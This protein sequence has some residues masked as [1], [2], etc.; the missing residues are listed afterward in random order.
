MSPSTRWV[1]RFTKCFHFSTHWILDKNWKYDFFPFCNQRKPNSKA[2][3][4]WAFISQII[5]Y[6]PYSVPV[7][8]SSKHYDWVSPVITNF[9]EGGTFCTGRLQCLC[10]L[11]RSLADPFLETGTLP[12]IISPKSARLSDLCIIK[13]KCLYWILTCHELDS[14]KSLLKSS[15]CFS[16]SSLIKKRKEKKKNLF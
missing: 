5:T 2:L 16:L 13:T 14:A 9:V 1:T 6:L 11:P 15:K 7:L 4:E 12:V 8:F 3:P 10:K